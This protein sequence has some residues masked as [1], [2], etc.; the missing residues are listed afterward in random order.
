M[1]A[2]KLLDRQFSENKYLTRNAKNVAQI[3]VLI[4]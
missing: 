1:S 3:F 2:V 4:V